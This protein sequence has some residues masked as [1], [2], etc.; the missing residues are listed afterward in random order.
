MKYMLLIYNDPSAIEALPQ[1]E[2]DELFATV[3]RVMEELTASGEL[4]GGEALAWA[5]EAKTVRVRDGVVATTD[6]P[7]AEAK[8]QFAGYLAVDVES[9][10][11]SLRAD[12]RPRGVS[13]SAVCPGVI[14]TPIVESTRFLG[15][16]SA[17]RDRMVKAFRRGHPPELVAREV[18]RSVR[19]DRIVVFPGVEARLGWWAH[20]LLPLR[21]HQFIARRDP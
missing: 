15:E 16:R 3:D 9:E 7:Y 20:R 21:V 4:V 12:W 18:L 17:K 19:E 11:Q 5:S 1:D 10:E 2:K 14:D 13:V 6:G 8:E